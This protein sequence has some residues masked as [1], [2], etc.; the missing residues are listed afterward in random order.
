MQCVVRAANEALRYHCW[1]LPR[2]TFW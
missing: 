1:Y 2:T